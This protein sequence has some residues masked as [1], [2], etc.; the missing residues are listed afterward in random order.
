MECMKIFLIWVRRILCYNTGRG[1]SFMKKFVFGF[2]LLGLLVS[3]NN[4][5]EKESVWSDSFGNKIVYDWGFGDASIIYTNSTGKELKLCNYDYADANERVRLEVSPDS[6]KICLLFKNSSNLA[7]YPLGCGLRIYQLSNTSNDLSLKTEKLIF[8][9][10]VS[11][12]IAITDE[13]ISYSDVSGE[14]YT[15]SF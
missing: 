10:Q 8:D 1:V 2:I 5:F 6:S 13:T 3:C 4:F 9:V 15:Y 7:V 11:S 14:V 12:I